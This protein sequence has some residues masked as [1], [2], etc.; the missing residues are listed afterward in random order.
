MELADTLDAAALDLAWKK[1]LETH[2]PAAIRSL[3]AEIKN[4]PYS[5]GE[6]LANPVVA[7]ADQKSEWVV[8]LK[9]KRSEAGLDALKSEIEGLERGQDAT[10]DRLKDGVLGI[11][12]KKR[13]S[14]REIW[15]RS[16]R[17]GDV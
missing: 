8:A 4:F 16:G 6:F 14:Y 1:L 17:E 5:M 12:D 15:A 13:A 9:R 10:M 11:I 7:A 2:D 3:V